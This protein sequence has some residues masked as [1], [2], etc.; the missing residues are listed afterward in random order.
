[1]WRAASLA[2]VFGLALTGGAFAVGDVPPACL[3]PATD[4]DMTLSGLERDGWIAVP[5]GTLTPEVR[6]LLVWS[7]VSDYLI[8]DTGGEDVQRLLSLQLGTVD[9]L[10]RK[11]DIPGSKARLLQQD[12]GAL[13]VFWRVATPE[14][15]EIQ[16]RA[17]RL[18]PEYPASAD[19]MDA[20]AVQ[21]VPDG[22]VQTIVL[23]LDGIDA[24]IDDAPVGGPLLVGHSLIRFAGVPAL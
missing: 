17:V 16:C 12:G 5:D 8:G 14:T 24:S 2:A 18:S 15:L 1:M 7:Y 19:L 22:T 11:R 3:T 4:L 23:N 9:A 6:D 20:G 21:A 10:A 13:A